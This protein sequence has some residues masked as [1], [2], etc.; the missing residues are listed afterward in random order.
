MEVSSNAEDPGQ[1]SRRYLQKFVAGEEV[2][3]RLE[4]GGHGFGQLLM[5]RLIFRCNVWLSL[6][7]KLEQKREKD[8]TLPVLSS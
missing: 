1:R 4:N 8:L 2:G 3:R 6:I 7:G 5:H